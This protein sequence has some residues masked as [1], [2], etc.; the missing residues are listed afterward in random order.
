MTVLGLGLSLGMSLGMVL[1]SM[2]LGL[3]DSSRPELQV[4]AFC[5]A[6]AHLRK[7]LHSHGTLLH[8]VPDLDT[9]CPGVELLQQGRQQALKEWQVW[10]FC[11]A[12]AQWREILPS[13]GSFSTLDQI[14]ATNDQGRGGG[15]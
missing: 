11:G 10:A 14:L 2:G 15:R 9:L 3:G 13:H 6:Q 7:H 8:P 4:W 5:G 1:L 12:Q